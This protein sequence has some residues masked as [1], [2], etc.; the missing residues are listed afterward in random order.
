MKWRRWPE[1]WRDSAEGRP[2]QGNAGLQLGFWPKDA[3]LELGAPGGQQFGVRLLHRILRRRSGLPRNYGGRT[4]LRLRR[5][6]SDLSSGRDGFRSYFRRD[7]IRPHQRPASYR[8]HDLRVQRAAAVPAGG[9][10]QPLAETRGER[11]MAYVVLPCQLAGGGSRSPDVR[12]LVHPNV[13]Y[14]L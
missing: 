13:S 11:R 3:E 9:T 14:P 10:A 7:V 2:V 6:T 4:D 8:F 12:R 5:V 1:V